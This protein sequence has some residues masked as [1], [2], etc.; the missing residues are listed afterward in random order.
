MNCISTNLP[1][2]CGHIICGFFDVIGKL[3]YGKK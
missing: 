2:K 3:L 1:F